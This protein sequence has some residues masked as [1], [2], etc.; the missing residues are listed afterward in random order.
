[1]N[2]LPPP[3]NTQTILFII[4]MESEAIPLRKLLNLEMDPQM[5]SNPI[6]NSWI[7]TFNNMKIVMMLAKPDKKYKID[8]IGPESAAIIT[9]IGVETYQPDLII[10]AGTA[11]AY[12]KYFFI[13]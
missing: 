10:S 3:P 12:E 13:R 4:A 11:G 1:M 8:S 5:E 7:G 6:A 9:Y 2:P